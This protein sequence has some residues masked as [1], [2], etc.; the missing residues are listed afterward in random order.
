MRH[1]TQGCGHDFFRLICIERTLLIEENGLKRI[2]ERKI[3]IG[4]KKQA[5]QVLASRCRI[6]QIGILQHFIAD[7]LKLAV[8]VNLQFKSLLDFIVTG[9]DFGELRI[10][11]AAL[12]RDVIEFYEHVRHFG[13]RRK[14]FPRSARHHI[15]PILIRMNNRSHLAE[16]S[17]IRKGTAAE[18]YNF[19]HITSR[20]LHVY[21]L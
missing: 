1:L 3:Q 15:D 11:I 12:D 8:E 21:F 18:F 19:F 2:N 4:S 14:A 20:K 10:Q 16:L 7:R 6:V 9:P 17:G 5:V 13:I